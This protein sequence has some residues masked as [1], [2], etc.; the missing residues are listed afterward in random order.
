MPLLGHWHLRLS[1][2]IETPLTASADPVALDQACA[3]LCCAATPLPNTM[4]TEQPPHDDHFCALDPLLKLK[5]VKLTRHAPHDFEIAFNAS[6]V[7]AKIFPVLCV[8]A[9]AGA[10]IFYGVQMVKNQEHTTSSSFFFNNFMWIGIIT[11]AVLPT[12]ATLTAISRGIRCD[13]LNRTFTVWWQIGTFPRKERVI[14][15]DYTASFG[16]EVVA[17]VD[18]VPT[19]YTVHLRTLGGDKHTFTKMI[20]GDQPTQALTRFLNAQLKR[21]SDA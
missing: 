12:L 5:R 18:D 16:T 19:H 15:F 7:F 20:K 10:F 13:T 1:K 21:T 14:A 2:G 17:S 3:D 11:F 8:L 6:Q 4:L 9:F